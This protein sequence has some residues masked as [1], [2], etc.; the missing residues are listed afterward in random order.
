MYYIYNTFTQY[1]NMSNI[2]YYIKKLNLHPKYSLTMLYINTVSC[3]IKFNVINIFK[4]MVLKLKYR[5]TSSNTI[6]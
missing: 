3:N 6:K 5:N 1:N 2:A 4:N